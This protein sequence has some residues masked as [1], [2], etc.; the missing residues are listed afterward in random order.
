MVGDDYMEK[1]DNKM[2]PNSVEWNKL[3]NQTARSFCPEIFPCKEC[4]KPYVRGYCCDYCG[5]VDP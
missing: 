3:A 2:D 5:S 4:G 1:K